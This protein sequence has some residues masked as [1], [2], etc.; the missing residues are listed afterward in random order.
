MDLSK[1]SAII[2]FS[3]HTGIDFSDNLYQQ[4]HAWKLTEHM[5]NIFQITILL[6]FLYPTHW[7]FLNI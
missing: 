6:P 1:G 2:M 5:L 3:E 4:N 7:R